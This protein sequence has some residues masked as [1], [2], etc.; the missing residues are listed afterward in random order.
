MFGVRH[1]IGSL[2]ARIVGGVD[3]GLHNHDALI[4]GDQYPSERDWLFTSHGIP[5]KNDY[6]EWRGNKG[7]LQSVCGCAKVVAQKGGKRET[8]LALSTRHAV[9]A[10]T[11]A[12]LRV[13]R[14]RISIC[15]AVS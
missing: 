7:R 8:S 15:S 9:H 10:S 4:K 6:R 12:F 13:S 14:L 1:V 5:G 3:A 11:R 2:M